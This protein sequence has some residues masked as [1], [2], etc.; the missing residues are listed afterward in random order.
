MGTSTSTSPTPS[1]GHG[2]KEWAEHTYRVHSEYICFKSK[3]IKLD[4]GKKERR[5]PETPQIILVAGERSWFFSRKQCSHT[6]EQHLHHLAGLPSSLQSFLEEAAPLKQGV[7]PH[8]CQ[9][10]RLERE[11]T[12]PPPVW[13]TCSQS[14]SVFSLGSRG[15]WV[16]SPAPPEISPMTGAWTRPQHA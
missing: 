3:Q 10:C 15:T 14:G 16:G 7:Q 11:D 12:E 2:V 9:H 8:P 13:R 6:S 1:G 4:C 5:L